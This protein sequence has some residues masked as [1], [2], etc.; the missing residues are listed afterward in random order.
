MEQI[1][2][3]F[4]QLVAISDQDWALF[5]SKLKKVNT[6]KNPAC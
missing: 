6:L 3:Y 4:E 1:R 2:N 5:S